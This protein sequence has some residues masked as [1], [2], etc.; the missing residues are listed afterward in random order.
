MFPPLSQLGS[1][2][3]LGQGV[4]WD[5]SQLAWEVERRA[6][7]LAHMGIGRGAM[8]AIA[9][10]GS[11]R[12][13]ADLLATWRLG[14][15]A[16][17][18]DSA[19]T[20][21]ELKT[22]LAFAKP[23]V[24]LTDGAGIS[25]GLPT[26]VLRLADMASVS[27]T[28]VGPSE[29]KA[30]DPALILFTSGTTGEPKGVVLSFGALKTRL[31]L[32][33]EAIGS[34]ALARTLVTLPT[35]FGHGLIGN[36]L[37]PLAAGGEIVLHPTGLA[38]AKNLGSIIDDQHITFMSSV[39]A[40]WRMVLKFSSPPSSQLL[41]R[42]HVGSAP[43]PAD[44]W[45]D[46]A[47]WSRADVVNC[48]G[49]TETAN[50]ISGASSRTDGIVDGAVGKPW[51][52][53]A[54]VVDANGDI[55]PAGEGE[56]VVQSPALMSGYFGRDDLTAAVMD[57]GWYRTGDRGIIDDRGKIRLIGRLKD[58]INRAG[59]KIQPAEIDRLLEAHP[60][61]AEACAFAVADPVGG[62]IVAVA[63]RLASDADTDSLRN[64]CRTRLRREA[65]PEKWFIVDDIPYN[66]RGKVSRDAVRRMLIKETPDGPN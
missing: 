32:N 41:S 57:R 63:V 40:L 42:L 12:F 6:A 34:A 55:R 21:P 13:F 7:C 8:V 46:I 16:I 54:A 37:T 47:R 5:P 31:A 20:D 15:T 56:L 10:G 38:L 27:P 2:N 18:L 52:G 19:L 1:I 50:W 24:L 9:H 64:W 51:G 3:D 59:F 61:V 58:E 26:D 22:V 23:A 29:F 44:L 35:H 60:A 17:C 53:T 30:A 4:R 62:E 36:A 65:V 33:A 45:S 39:P 28:S 49:I 43:L 11:A 48:Y 66:A 14:A 25:S